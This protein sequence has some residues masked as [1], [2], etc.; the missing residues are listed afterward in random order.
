MIETPLRSDKKTSPLSEFELEGSLNA[1][2]GW[3]YLLSVSN[4]LMIVSISV[5]LGATRPLL[6]GIIK[7]V[8]VRQV[9]RL[10][11]SLRERAP[12]RKGRPK[13][14]IH[15]TP[16]ET[17]GSARFHSAAA[18]PAGTRR[19]VSPEPFSVAGWTVTSRT[20]AE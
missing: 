16:G 10:D 13:F 9:R 2:T 5:V 8:T 4:F 18:I 19:S 12:P 7:Q 17:A 15:K 11:H 14:E 20:R 3:R 1:V 6:T